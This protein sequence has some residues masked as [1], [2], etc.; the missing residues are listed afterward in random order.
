MSYFRNRSSLGALIQREGTTVSATALPSTSISLEQSAAQTADEAFLASLPPCSVPGT[1]LYTFKN[2]T[3]SCVRDPLSVRAQEAAGTLGAKVTMPLYNA[4]GTIR[5]G[6]LDLLLKAQGQPG[7]Q[8]LAQESGVDWYAGY[9]GKPAT[10]ITPIEPGEMVGARLMMMQDLARSG[11]TP[12]KIAEAKGTP[13]EEGIKLILAVSAHNIASTHLPKQRED[14]AAGTGVSTHFPADCLTLGLPDL[15][16]PCCANAITRGGFGIESYRK[17][18]EKQDPT[19]MAC[20]QAA[21]QEDAA[22]KRRN[23][24]MAAGAVG[25]VVLGAA[26]LKKGKKK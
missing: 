23:V 19:V 10:G 26:F 15:Y 4:D 18:I 12:R 25:V 24:I 16:L 22:R 20:F 21:Q 9:L 17:A 6:Y 8:I 3:K 1:F 7:M 5:Q 2:G 14:R 11:F 13:Q